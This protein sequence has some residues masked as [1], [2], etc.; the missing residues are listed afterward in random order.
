[1]KR[2]PAAMAVVLGVAFA[3]TAH[4]QTSV[5][6]YGIVDEGFNINTNSGGSHLYDLT[7]GVLAGSRW[8]FRGT[9]DLGGGLKVTFLLENG[10]DGSNGSLGQGG[11]IFG[12]QAYVSLGSSQFGT[13]TLG[14]QY[15]SVVDY[16]GLL[17]VGDQWG[18]YIAAHPG[19]VDNFNNTSV[20]NNAIKFTSTNYAGLTFGG[21]YSVGGVAGDY[22]RNQTW[23]LGA[24]YT[25]G[26]FVLGVGYLNAR[27]P[28]T[29]GGLFGNNTTTTTASA[30]TTPVYAGFASARTY[31]VVGAGGAYTFGAATFGV[32]YSNVKFYG[33]GSTSPSA[34]N[35]ETAT[36]NDAEV[37]FKYQITPTLLVG[38]AYN[39]TKGNDV[40]P[41]DGSKYHQGMLG[42]D[43]FISRRTDVYAI[44]VY[45]H[46]SG[47]QV[48]ANGAT[49]APAR[50]A[51][52]GL[53]ASSTGNQ[54]TARVGIRHQF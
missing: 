36:F 35:G 9:E 53:T 17:E 39:Y 14:R 49:I 44:G 12:R 41:G 46:A 16:V 13:V 43:Y 18:G 8:G 40:G 47:E 22:S 19:D 2:L 52:N 3:C 20:T 28:A 38:A 1:M 54:V 37:N 26:P 31:Q 51:I 10:F 32:T 48:S 5:A 33:I 7:S 30:V 23:S 50:A 11:L 24:G 25:N 45:Q 29:S 42:V 27:T 6:L 21:M 4:A 15:D 34:L